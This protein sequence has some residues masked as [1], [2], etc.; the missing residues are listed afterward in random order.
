MADN[1]TVRAHAYCTYFDSGYLPRALAL[2]DSLQRH[3]DDSPIW[4]L[5]LDD[6]TADTLRALDR[7][8]LHVITARD[9]EAAVPELAPLRAKRT[10][11]EYY[12]TQTPLLMR[13][14][15]DVLGTP[16]SV[17][18]YL[19]ADLFFFDSPIRVLDALGEDRSASS[20][21][22]TRRSSRRS[23]RST[24]NTTSAG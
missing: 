2:F 12:F 13:Y 21:T 6:E 5:A 17:A 24:A 19:D 8:G 4:V 1:I 14:V 11:M 3:G 9:L 20:S 18:I 7:A 22:V 16:G 23:W 15:L 10:R